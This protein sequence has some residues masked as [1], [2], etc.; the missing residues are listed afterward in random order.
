[1]IL[2]PAALEK[3]AEDALNHLLVTRSSPDSSGAPTATWWAGFC[4]DKAGLFTTA[5]AWNTHVAEY[6]RA[7]ASPI[8]VTVS[9]AK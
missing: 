8:Q 3:Q 2:P 5:E 4:W 9:A 1:M 7:L 6:A